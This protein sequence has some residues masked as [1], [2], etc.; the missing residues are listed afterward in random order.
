MLDYQTIL[1][2]EFVYVDIDGGHLIIFSGGDL[3]SSEKSPEDIVNGYLNV[4]GDMGVMD[5][6]EESI[7]AVIVD[8]DE[9]I[10]VSVSSFDRGGHI[11]EPL[12]R[13]EYVIVNSNEL[14][15]FYLIGLS[16][17][18]PYKISWE[19]EG[20]QVFDAILDTI[21]FIPVVSEECDCEISTDDTYGYTQENP[22]RV[23]GGKID[24]VLE[25]LDN[26][27]GPEGQEISYEYPKNADVLDDK[28]I[29][30]VDVSVNYEGLAEPFKLYFD[31]VHKDELYAPVGLTCVAEFIIFIP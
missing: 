31:L 24:R 20:E 12:F 18:Y 25:Y 10:R 3:R 6:V 23:G 26:L 8:G 16:S 14:Q 13:G 29:S 9:G 1:T 17:E 28:E 2:C 22:I 19:D 21:E 30:I 11:S 5:F 27:L 15:Y 4:L 7:D